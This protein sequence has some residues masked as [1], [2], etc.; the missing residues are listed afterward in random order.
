MAN[1]IGRQIERASRGLFRV[2]R[3]C[4]EATADQS[5]SAVPRLRSIFATQPKIATGHEETYAA[6][7]RK[8][9]QLMAA[10]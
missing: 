5:I 2:I 1:Q 7:Q 4:A 10:K 3:A 6:L 9:P 8:R